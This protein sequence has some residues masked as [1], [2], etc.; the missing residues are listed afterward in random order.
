MTTESDENGHFEFT[1]I[2]YGEYVV[3]EIAAPTGYI[4]SDEL[5][6]LIISGDSGQRAF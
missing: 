4:L 2:P 6:H 3:R 5:E 1:E